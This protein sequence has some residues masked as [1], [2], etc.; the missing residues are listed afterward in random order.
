[1][2]HNKETSVTGINQDIHL[3]LDGQQRLTFLFIGLKGSYR[4]FYYRW[5]KTN[6]T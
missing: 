4:Y 6:F 3:I 1:M 5:T 2:P